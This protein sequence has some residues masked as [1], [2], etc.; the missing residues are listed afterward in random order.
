[1]SR[2]EKIRQGYL[3]LSTICMLVYLACGV[4]AGLIYGLRY[5]A[6][7]LQSHKAAAKL[8]DDQISESADGIEE[9]EVLRNLK[10]AGWDYV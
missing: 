10:A 5:I 7:K 8:I 6:Q 3:T 4:I 1:M 2:F 9:D